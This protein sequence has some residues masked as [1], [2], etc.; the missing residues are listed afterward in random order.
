M[1]ESAL[2]KL[3]YGVYLITVWADGKP[4]GCVANAC[5]Q[6]TAEPPKVIISLNKTCFTNKHVKETGVFAVSVLGENA[7]VSLISE[8]GFAS[9]AEV[10]KFENYDYIIKDNLPVLPSAV[11]YLTCKV[12]DEK[13]TDTHTI[14]LAQVTDADNLSDDTPMTYSYYHKE[15]KGKTSPKAPTYKNGG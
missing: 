11:S 3:S 12:L 6:V 13:E 9:G 7:D 1:N 10:N 5:L 14:F 8:F 2:F 4:T 15:L